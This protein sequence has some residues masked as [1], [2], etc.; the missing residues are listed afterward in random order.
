MKISKECMAGQQEYNYSLYILTMMEVINLTQ[1][2]NK[3]YYLGHKVT[4]Q[5][6]ASLKF[7]ILCLFVT[8]AP[9]KTNKLLLGECN[10]KSSEIV[11]LHVA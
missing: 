7:F 5:M 8:L 9:P 11:K 10:I 3:S 4:Q 6:M 1:V 2:H